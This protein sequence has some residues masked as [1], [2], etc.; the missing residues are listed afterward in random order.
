MPILVF[1]RLQSHCKQGWRKKF[2]S[3]GMNNWRAKWAGKNWNCCMQSVYNS[4]N[5]LCIFVNSC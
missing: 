3:G 2:K 1:N 5:F 4:S